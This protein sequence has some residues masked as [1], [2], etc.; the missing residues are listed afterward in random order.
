M[1]GALFYP[2]ADRSSQWFGGELPGTVMPMTRPKLLLHT[3]ETAGGWPAYSGGSTGPTL[4]YDPWVR[5][6]RQH[7]RVSQSARALRD[8][9][10]TPV[11]ENRA[12]VVQVEISCYCDPA[13]FSTGRGI[14]KLSAE[15]YDDLGR[16]V[17]FLHL[18]WNLP[19]VAVP[20]WPPYPASYGISNGVRMTS[21]E[22][23]T[24]SGILGHMHAPGQDHGDPGTLDVPRILDA[25]R[26]HIT[27]GRRVDRAL[28]LL[29]ADLDRTDDLVR[30]RHLRAAV[31]ELVEIEARL[32]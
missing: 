5:K 4:T 7:F 2:P 14:D 22:Y 17:A 28:E 31:S 20:K 18:E 27:R 19:F 16:F 25:A 32:G 11:R 9:E 23:E 15:A 8:P 26:D 12:D 1:S 13:R 21:A 3:T 6:W 10:S 24:F 30:K 29:R